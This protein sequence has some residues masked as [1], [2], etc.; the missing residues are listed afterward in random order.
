L[1]KRRRARELALQFLFQSDLNS[2]GPLSGDDFTE[3]SEDI[4]STQNRETEG[5]LPGDGQV[6]NRITG[7]EETNFQNKVVRP[8]IETAIYLFWESF[9][10]DDT[11]W[12]FFLELVEGVYKNKVEIDALINET[13]ENWKLDRMAVVDRNILRFSVYELLYVDDIPPSVTMNEA[14]ELAKRYGAEDSPSFINGILDK[15]AALGDKS[16]KKRE[17]S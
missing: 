11:V 10:T 15:I 8:E 1:G 14:I 16:E 5:V 7:V 3:S 17:S 12:P 13:S 4:K 9:K 2:P 6:P